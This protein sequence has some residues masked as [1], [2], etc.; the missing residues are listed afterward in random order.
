MLYM[1]LLFFLPFVLL[2]VIL[3]AVYVWQPWK[4]AM[5]GYEEV[6]G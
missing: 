3:L 6:A 5:R 2:A 4:N 1:K